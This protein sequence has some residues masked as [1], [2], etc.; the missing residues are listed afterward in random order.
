ML[1]KGYLRLAIGVVLGLMGGVSL[2]LTVFPFIMGQFLNAPTFDFT[3][4]IGYVGPI[5]LLW[6]CA[7]GVVGWY[8]GVRAGLGVLGICGAVSGFVLGAFAIG[9][10]AQ[11][12]WAGI[13]AGLIYGVPAGL[14][15]GSAFPSS[16]NES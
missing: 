14:L 8:G 6:A 11:L 1:K 9:G 10:E 3:R 5:A 2:T 4:L 13:V 12:M 7:G 15:I 16:V